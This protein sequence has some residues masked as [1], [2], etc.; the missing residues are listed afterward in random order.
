MMLVAM[1]EQGDEDTLLQGPQGRLLASLATAMGTG[2][3][4]PSTSRPRC[5]GTCR[6]PD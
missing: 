5:R 2:P 1:P 6:L 3:R 4:E